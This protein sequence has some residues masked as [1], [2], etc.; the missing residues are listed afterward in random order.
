MFCF[1]R[2]ILVALCVWC[3]ESSIR[4]GADV[5]DVVERLDTVDGL[6]G[7]GGMGG[8]DGMDGMDESKEVVEIKCMGTVLECLK[9]GVIS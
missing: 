6:N 4:Y 3:F 7:M 8:M 9:G 5:S 1:G 2:S